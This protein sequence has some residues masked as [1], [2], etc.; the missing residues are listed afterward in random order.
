MLVVV[1]LAGGNGATQPLVQSKTPA[2]VPHTVV[3]HPEFVPASSATFVAGG[4]CVDRDS[5][6]QSRE[7]LPGGRRW[8]ARCRARP[9]G[10]RPI[11]VTLCGICNTGIVFRAEAK[12]QVL[13]FD[14]QGLEGLVGANEVF[15]DRET[16]SRW[17]Q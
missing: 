13:H 8:T 16:G 17:Q 5:D 1:A 2:K 4:G 15:K 9:N 6:R 7:G 11:A 3:D 12:G 14:S 10:R